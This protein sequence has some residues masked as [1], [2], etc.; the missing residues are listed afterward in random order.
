MHTPNQ[1]RE[2]GG[3]ILN[4]LKLDCGTTLKTKYWSHCKSKVEVNTRI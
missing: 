2:E 4:T 1:G 3:C